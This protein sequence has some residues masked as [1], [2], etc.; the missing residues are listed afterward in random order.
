MLK[1]MLS[2]TNAKRGARD[3]WTV[4]WAGFFY[5]LLAYATFSALSYGSRSGTRI[6]VVLLLATALGVWYA[7]WLLARVSPPGDLV[8][9]L[10][11]SGLWVALIAIDPDFL[12]LGLG[13]FMPLCLH[14]YRWAGV[15]FMVVAGGWIWQLWTEQGS[16]PGPAVL[17]ILLSLVAG[18]L[19]VAYVATI[20]RQSQERQRLIEQLHETRSEL[21]KAERQAGVLEERQRLA[22]DIHDTLTQGFASI[23]MLLEAAEASLGLD[24]P[25]RRPVARALQSARDNLAESRRLVWALRP[26][27][28]TNTPLP[29]ALERLTKQLAEQTGIRAETVVTGTARALEASQE[30]GLLRAAQESLTNVHKHARA[31]EVTVTLSYMDD[32]TV[33]DIHDDG[34]GF[35]PPARPEREGDGGLG[36]RAMGERIE[37]MG[38]TVSVESS[39]GEGTTVVVHLPVGPLQPV[40]A[41]ASGDTS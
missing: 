22:R 23:V 14:D 21:A 13:I 6:T 28:L 24:H 2:R 31:S 37:K 32:I 18:L 38:G 40:E 17:G 33:L 26:E 10:G 36:L 7:Y 3:R 5:V 27:A 34:V 39:P 16:I 41:R 8:Y 9:L 19:T 20:V 12:V 4:L 30:T 15:G 1:N 29:N 11:A 35:V 25:G